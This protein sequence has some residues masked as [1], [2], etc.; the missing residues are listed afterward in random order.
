MRLDKVI[1]GIS[2]LLIVALI[3]V[4][5]C[6]NTI[7]DNANTVIPAW[8]IVMGISGVLGFV[9]CIIYWATQT[10]K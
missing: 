8:Q 2:I 7:N 9:G 6:H 4:R 5:A 1:F 10:D 3:I